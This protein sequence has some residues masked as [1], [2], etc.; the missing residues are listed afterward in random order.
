MSAIV[1][2]LIGGVIAAGLCALALHLRG[3]AST[4]PDGWRWLRPGWLIYGQTFGPAMIAAFC[5]VFLLSGGSSRADAGEQNMLAAL[6]MAVFLLMAIY[7]G[8]TGLLRR[9]AWRG[10]RLRIT[11]PSRGS[12]VVG[13]A[14]VASVCRSSALG[15][16]V[17]RFKDGSSVRLSEYLHGTAELMDALGASTLR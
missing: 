7:S 5:G 3:S 15:E 1:S 8:W 10:D 11:R 13:F 17:I 2:G 16:Y 4:D 12:Q 9:V 14:D 6:L